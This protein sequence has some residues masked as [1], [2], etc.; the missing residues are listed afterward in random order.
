MTFVVG[1]CSF[2]VGVLS[3]E[4]HFGILP[5]CPGSSLFLASSVSPVSPI[6]S[7]LSFSLSWKSLV[8]QLLYVCETIACYNSCFPAFVEDVSPISYPRPVV[9]TNEYCRPHTKELSVCCSH[10]FAYRPPSSAWCSSSHIFGLNPCIS[11]SEWFHRLT[12]WRTIASR[13]LLS[14]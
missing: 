2:F 13:F 7:W 12:A 4:L 8:V 14:S 6:S 9:Q 1:V 11:E 3:H 5:K 10:W